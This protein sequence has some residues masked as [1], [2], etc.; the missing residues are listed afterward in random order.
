M[1]KRSR[2]TIQPIR[3]LKFQR[4]VEKFLTGSGPGLPE[5]L[6]LQVKMSKCS[7]RRVKKPGRRK[8]VLSR[9]FSMLAAARDSSSIIQTIINND[10]HKER[11]TFEAATAFRE[12]KKNEELKKQ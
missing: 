9:A 3:M 8:F 4:C 7:G 1:L 10:G 12:R 2:D 11:T 6:L 5:D